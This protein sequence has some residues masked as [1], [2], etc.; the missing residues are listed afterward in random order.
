MGKLTHQLYPPSGPVNQELLQLVHMDVY[1]P[2]PM[3]SAGGA[4]YLVTFL[5]EHSKFGEVQL[6]KSKDLVPA[7]VEKVLKSWE[8]KTRA[9]VHEVCTDHGSEYVNACLRGV[10][11]ELG[12][13]HG[14]SAPYTPRQNSEAEHLNFNLLE[15]VH[16]MMEGAPKC[17][18]NM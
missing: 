5:D 18:K 1:G 10:F 14:P 3:E 4:K 7:V 8:T 16:T 13:V 9:K 15:Q 12:V 11:S 2:M 6:I 17:P